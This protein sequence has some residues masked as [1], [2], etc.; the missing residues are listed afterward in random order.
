M[1]Q[2]ECLMIPYSKARAWLMCGFLATLAFTSC[3][4]SIIIT[5]LYILKYSENF[6]LNCIGRL[7]SKEFLKNTDYLEISARQGRETNIS[8]GLYIFLLLEK[9]QL[10]IVLF[11]FIRKSNLNNIKD[12]YQSYSVLSILYGLDC[13]PQSVCLWCSVPEGHIQNTQSDWRKF[14]RHSF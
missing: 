8:F 6:Q 1:L 11:I 13:R 7:Y 5:E 2:F 12:L 10:K 14:K 3:P 4:L 9:T